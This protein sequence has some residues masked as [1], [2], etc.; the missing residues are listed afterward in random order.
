M[1]RVGWR[2]ATSGLAGLV[3]GAYVPGWLLGKK[4]SPGVRN[5][6]H[7][8][9]GSSRTGL[10]GRA[11]HVPCAIRLTLIAPCACACGPIHPNSRLVRFELDLKY[12]TLMGL[13]GLGAAA[14]ASQ[15]GPS[16][17]ASSGGSSSISNTTGGGS[18]SPSSEEVAAAVE[19]LGMHP[20]DLAALIE[21]RLHSDGGGG[22][23][24]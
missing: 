3:V 20:G 8:G 2:Q 7:V 6:Q 16:P 23:R 18:S 22:G 15:P 12:Q 14:N 17:A 5:I 13:V 1:A 11:W 4:A 9:L 21:V 10:Y 19:L 24:L